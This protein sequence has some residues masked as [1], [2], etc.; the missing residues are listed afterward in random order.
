M[1]TCIVSGS[2]LSGDERRTWDPS[3]LPINN[4]QILSTP[5]GASEEGRAGMGSVDSRTALIVGFYCLCSGGM[6]VINK[7]AIH[8]INVPAFVTIMQFAATS[9]V[10]A[11]GQTRCPILALYGRTCHNALE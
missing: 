1:Y 7:V 5:K 11:H 9:A 3:N 6:L 8:Y 4:S 10:R 2:T